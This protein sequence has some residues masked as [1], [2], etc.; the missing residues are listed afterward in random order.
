M[1]RDVITVE[2]VAIVHLDHL[3]ARFVIIGQRKIAAVNVIE[4]AEVHTGDYALSA[5]APRDTA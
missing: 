5:L 1:F 2:A 4:N 3:Q